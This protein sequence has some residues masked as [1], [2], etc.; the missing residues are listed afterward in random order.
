MQPD[1]LGDRVAAMISELKTAQKTISDLRLTQLGQQAG[2]LVDQ[3]VDL[4]GVWF[5][6]N[7]ATWT[8]ARCAR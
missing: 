8:P 5:A 7:W 4:G 2:S 6:S 3:A 1:Q